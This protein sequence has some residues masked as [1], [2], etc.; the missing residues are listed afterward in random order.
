MQHAQQLCLQR[1][2]QFA[3]FVQKQRAALGLFKQAAVLFDR[4]GK[5]AFFVAKQHVFNHVFGQGGAVQA[6]KRAVGCGRRLMQHARQHFFARSGGAFDQHG[7]GGECHALG[8]GQQVAADGVYVNDAAHCG[9]G[10]GRL[11]RD[12]SGFRYRFFGGGLG[13]AIQRQAP[14]GF[15]P[16][17]GGQHVA[18]AVVQGQ[19]GEFQ[20]AA[21]KAADQGHA[22]ARGVNQG[23]GVLQEFNVGTQ[24]QHHGRRL[25]GR[26]GDCG[27]QFVECA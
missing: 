15:R 14:G 11:V 20:L 25:A 27:L 4:A 6:N 12:G 24:A 23:Q 3:N 9:A 17:V 5:S 22:A 1:K 7:H 21:L 19:H 26:G 10:I 8:Q 13:G 2:G 16:V 18:G